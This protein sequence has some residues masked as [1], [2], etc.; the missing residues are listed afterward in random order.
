MCDL[1]FFQHS[2]D[3]IVILDRT[4]EHKLSYQKRRLQ[5][6]SFL[7]ENKSIHYFLR[8]TEYPCDFGV[9]R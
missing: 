5:K 2:G 9:N 4:L 8:S 1:R 6:H 3:P 7:M